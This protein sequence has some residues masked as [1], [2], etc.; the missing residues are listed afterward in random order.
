MIDRGVIL[1]LTADAGTKR[2]EE[3]DYAIAHNGQVQVLVE[4][5]K[6]ND[7]VRIE[8]ASQLFGHYAV[9]DARIAILTNEKKYQFH[10]DLDSP[11]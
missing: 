5:R 3:V 6:A 4:A 1:D 11:N 2:G 8:P 9:T 7:P 10:I